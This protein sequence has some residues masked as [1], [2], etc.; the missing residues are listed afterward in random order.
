MNKQLLYFSAV[1]LKAGKERF[2][3]IHFVAYVYTKDKNTQFV[4]HNS[5]FYADLMCTTCFCPNFGYH[6]VLYEKHLE[7]EYCCTVTMSR[8]KYLIFLLISF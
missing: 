2:T 5:I 1:F 8:L 6:Q 7:E 4:I 3:C